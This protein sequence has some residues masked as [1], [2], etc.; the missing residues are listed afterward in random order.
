MYRIVFFS[1]ARP[2]PRQ[3]SRKEIPGKS[4]GKFVQ[5]RAASGEYL[6]F[7]PLHVSRY[8]ADIIERFCN[9]HGIPGI[10]HD[11]EKRFEILDDDWCVIGGGKFMIDTKQR[12]IRLFDNSMAYGKFDGNG[13]KGKIL[14]SGWF[15]GYDV[16]IE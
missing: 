5:L 8:H 14:S 12:K 7:A 10:Y 16:L 1:D 3:V 6:V 15:Q 4:A 2:F 13:M 9:K 11:T